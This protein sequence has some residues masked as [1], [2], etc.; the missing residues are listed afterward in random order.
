[1]KFQLV[2]P[3]LHRT[4]AAERAISNFKYHSIAGLAS[5]DTSFPNAPML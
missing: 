5:V 1:M 3:N 4:N 2:S